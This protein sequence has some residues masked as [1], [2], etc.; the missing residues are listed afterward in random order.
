MR[1]SSWSLLH[2]LPSKSKCKGYFIPSANCGL[3]HTFYLIG[4]NKFPW[5]LPSW[6][7]LSPLAIP[8]FR[9]KTPVSYGLYT[10]TL[11]YDCLT[12]KLV[13]SWNPR[14]LRGGTRRHSL[15]IITD[16]I[17]WQMTRLTIGV[18]QKYLLICINLP[19]I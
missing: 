12:W 11:L 5:T 2:P 9:V 15:P 10:D 18:L 13:L 6:P 14:A 16:F 7:L 3:I 19:F 17:T 1:V 8:E 4:E